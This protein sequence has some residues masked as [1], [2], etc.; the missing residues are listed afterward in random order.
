MLSL[1][2]EYKLGKAQ[3]FQ[4]LHDTRYPLVTERPA[5]C[6]NQSEMEGKK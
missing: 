2:E 4:M 6:D 3:L 1:V 5:F